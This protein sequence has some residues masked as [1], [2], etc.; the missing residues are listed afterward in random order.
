ML[1]SFNPA[2]PTIL[3]F[4]WYTAKLAPHLFQLF[5]PEKVDAV[6]E[7]IRVLG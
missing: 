1:Y 3:T 4:T 6:L 5:Y 7:G 2:H